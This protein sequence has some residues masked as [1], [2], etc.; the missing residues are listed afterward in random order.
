[1]LR[2]RQY[3]K[4]YGPEPVLEIKDLEL[5]AGVYWLKGENGA[6]KTTLL[7]SI[8]GLIPFEGEIDVAGFSLRRQRRLYTKAV[9]FAE[10]EPVFPAF[11]SANELV[12]FYLQ[13]KGGDA[14]QTAQMAR[15]FHLDSY[16][17]N[18]VGT[19]SSGMLKKLSLILAFTGT[20]K[21]ILLDEPFVT[22]D[23]EAVAF[24]REMISGSS[25]QGVSFLISSHQEL[26]LAVSYK[27][28]HLHH[29]KIEQEVYVAGA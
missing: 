27:T 5:A 18:Q 3:K 12:Q 17:S 19:Y 26:S 22:L 11:L 8:A 24:L 10:A 23:V 25:H 7:K 16:L 20:P 9:S 4:A 13:T 15:A 6:G 21:L 2:L 29:K 14:I 28:L 1:M